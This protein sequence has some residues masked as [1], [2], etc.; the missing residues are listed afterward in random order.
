MGRP[1]TIEEQ[2]AEAKKRREAEKSLNA[3]L[4]ARREARRVKEKTPKQPKQPTAQQLRSQR[5][6]ALRKRV[7]PTTGLDKLTEALT[8]PK[9]PKKK[10][11]R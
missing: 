9:K 3:A 10:K 2:R 6:A 8:Q 4:A 1:A 7:T 5:A 11:R